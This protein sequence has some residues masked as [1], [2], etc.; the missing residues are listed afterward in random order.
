M[1]DGQTPSEPRRARKRVD[2]SETPVT[3][4]PEGNPNART[5]YICAM[6]GLIPGLGLVLGPPAVI[7]GRR[8]YAAAK[9]ELEGKGIAHSWISILLGGLETVLSV[10]GLFLIGW[11]LGWI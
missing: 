2:R 9:K 10:A 4:L 8:G 3:F 6:V 5:A 11:G 1:T 7:Y